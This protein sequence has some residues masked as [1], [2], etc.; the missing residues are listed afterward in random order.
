MSRSKVMRSPASIERMRAMA[1]DI[2]LTSPEEFGSLIESEMR[3]WGK[4]VAALGL[5]KN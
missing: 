5:K 3:R 4:V 1:V 2:V